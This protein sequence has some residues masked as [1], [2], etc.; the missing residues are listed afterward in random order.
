[1]CTSLYVLVYYTVN[2]LPNID[3]WTCVINYIGH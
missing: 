2:I 1:M 3:V